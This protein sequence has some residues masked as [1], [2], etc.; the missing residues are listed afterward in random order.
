MAAEAD[1][2]N[3]IIANPE[4]IDLRLVFADWYEE[5][6]DERGEFIRV[7]LA[8]ARL[9]RKHPWREEME[10]KEKSLLSKHR[11]KWNS[12]LYRQLNNTTLKGKIRAR[13]ST[14]RGWRYRRGFVEHLRISAKEW[15]LYQDDF[16][17]VGP[18]TELRLYNTT[19]QDLGKIFTSPHFSNIRSL[20][21]SH[22]ELG[23]AGIRVLA[24]AARVS[25]LRYLN[26]ARNEITMQGAAS[27]IES[28]HLKGL[29]Q[30]VLSQNPMGLDVCRL[31]SSHFG[32]A[33]RHEN[34]EMFGKY[35]WEVAVRE[36]EDPDTRQLSW[37][38]NLVFD[39]EGGHH[40]HGRGFDSELDPWYEEEEDT[41]DFF[42]D[43]RE[44]KRSK[45]DLDWNPPD[46]DSDEGYS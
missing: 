25:S 13:R 43:E 14:V 5:H 36:S 24:G 23:D 9:P 30:I 3:A 29:T 2:L 4:D 28:D 44:K 12:E 46:D 1:F 20:D 21:L 27:L 10:A 16:S 34:G 45:K 6:G 31:L 41:R 11:K 32:N 26:L 42:P 40:R 39:Q 22:N 7:Q 19:A 37:D 15:L 38:D 33:A 17:R 35:A 18:I 8:L